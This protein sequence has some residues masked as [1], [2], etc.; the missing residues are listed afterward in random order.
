MSEKKRKPVFQEGPVTAEFIARS[1]QS[2]STKHSIGGHS[3]FLGQV[4]ADRKEGRTV[5]AIEYTA[6][7]SMAEEVLQ[8]IREETF[9]RY[10]LTCMHIHHSLGVVNAGEMCL[11]VFTSSVHRKEAIRA[12]EEVVERIKKEVPVWGR[13]ILDDE[14]YLWKENT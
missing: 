1:I 5:K 9:S 14:S 6:H 7:V 11:F 4:R 2:H 13:E 12:C 3:I 10:P 8:S